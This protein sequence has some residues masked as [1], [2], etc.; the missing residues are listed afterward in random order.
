MT[1]SDVKRLYDDLISTTEGKRLN[2]YRVVSHGDSLY[3][4]S[5]KRSGKI[6]IVKAKDEYEAIKGVL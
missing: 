4:V 5:D 2:N 1:N 3:S 6:I